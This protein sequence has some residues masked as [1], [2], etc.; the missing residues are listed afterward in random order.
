MN[1]FGTSN[2][3]DCSYHTLDVQKYIGTRLTIYMDIEYPISRHRLGQALSVT[4]FATY[5]FKVS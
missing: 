5:Y 3:D 1:Q 4:V 2:G